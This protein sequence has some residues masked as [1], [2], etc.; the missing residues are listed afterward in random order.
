MKPI[1]RYAL[2]VAAIGG[3][4]WLLGPYE[5]VRLT[6]S[7]E[8]AE[9]ERSP[10]GYFKLREAEYRDIRPGTEKRVIWAKTQ[11]QKTPWS[12]VYIHGFSATSEEIRPVP[13]RVAEGLEANLVFTRL[14]GHGR[15]GDAMA[16]AKVQDWINDVA[17]ALAV[18]R[19]V[20][21]R[22]LV[23]STSTGGT[24]VA[25]AAHDPKMMKNI[26]GSVFVSPN[27]GLNH[28]AAPLLTSPGA[29]YWLPLIVGA[30]RSFEPRNKRHAQF[31]TT[32][33]PTVA[34]FPMAALVK[35]VA[36]LDHASVSLP[37]LFIYSDADE[38]VDPTITN[39]V[40]NE[41]G[42]PTAVW[43]PTLTDRDDPRSHVIAGSIMSPGPT[44]DTIGAILQWVEGL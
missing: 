21:D 16:E 13:D 4:L 9:I 23:I 1:Y 37:A 41:W 6:P 11:G 3:L 43:R 5:R 24:L 2:S 35:K 19:A 7:L 32:S 31:W 29:R 26:A 34:V 39:R 30:E 42:G 18:A 15:T 33:Y 27:F 22:V 14:R 12:V 28:G 38:V 25:A 36:H 10:Q 20:G 44:Y 8:T 17:E 40:V